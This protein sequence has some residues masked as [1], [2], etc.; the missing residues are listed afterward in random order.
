[1]GGKGWELSA[2]LS[3]QPREM[4]A[5]RAAV[6]LLLVAVASAAAPPAALNLQVSRMAVCPHEPPLRRRHRCVNSG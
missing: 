3:R 5:R 1:M 6:A 2:G 4:D